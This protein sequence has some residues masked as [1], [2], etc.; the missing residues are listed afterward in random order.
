MFEEEPV[1]SVK[2][3]ETK[4][5]I[6]LTDE[7]EP[8]LIRVG[9]AIDDMGI[10][11]YSMVALYVDEDEPRLVPRSTIEPMLSATECVP[12]EIVTHWKHRRIH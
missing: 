10:V 11:D 8:Q 1:F 4:S 9:P 7:G 2:M 5:Y 3:I 6:R 12:L